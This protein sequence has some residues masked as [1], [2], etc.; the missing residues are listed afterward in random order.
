[1]QLWICFC[2]VRGQTHDDNHKER[3]EYEALGGWKD[4]HSVRGCQGVKFYTWS[5]RGGTYI[6]PWGG[7]G[8]ER[9][10][11][12]TLPWDYPWNHAS[13]RKSPL[14]CPWQIFD[15]DTIAR[16]LWRMCTV[17]QTVVK[18]AFI[19]WVTSEPWQWF[20]GVPHPTWRQT[21]PPNLIWISKCRLLSME[22]LWE[23]A[24]NDACRLADMSHIRYVYR[25]YL[26]RPYAVG[27]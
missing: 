6:Y 17:P 8:D 23:G 24:I 19:K 20:T 25:L 11:Y 22:A 15:V 27:G 7:R 10:D 26:L 16:V 1:M 3:F 14:L 21:F 2:C 12:F 9:A 18:D 5:M 4:K 13:I